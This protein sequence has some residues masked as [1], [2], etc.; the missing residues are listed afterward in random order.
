M[1]LRLEFY[2]HVSCWI[3]PRD[4]G[5]RGG[6]NLDESRIFQFWNPP[7]SASKGVKPTIFVPSHRFAPVLSRN[8]AWGFGAGRS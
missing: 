3:L 5:R 4:L 2:P 8:P 7:P 6:E 1:R